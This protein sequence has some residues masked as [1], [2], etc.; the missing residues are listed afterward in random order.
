MKAK[1]PISLVMAIP[2]HPW[3]KAT[4]ESAAVRIAMTVAESG[5]QPGSL[6]TVMRESGLDTDDPHLVLSEAR[7]TINSNLSEGADVTS[8]KSLVANSGISCNGM[9]LAGRGFVLTES[10]ASHLIAT[11]GEGARSIIK[12]F[13]NGGELV[14]RWSRRY[15]IDAYGKTADDIRKFAP[16][17]F[18]HLLQAVKPE[19]DLNRRPSFVRRWWIF[20][21]PRSTFRPALDNLNR[22]IGT[23]ETAK[24]RLFQFLDTEVLPDNMVIAIAS[25]DAFHLGVL[26]SKVHSEIWMPANAASLGVFIGNVRYS[27]SRCF[28]PFPFPV[29]DE[30]TRVF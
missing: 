28:D 10:Q 3:T 21:E 8:A 26:S 2:D 12:P 24:H 17:T 30:F 18:Q 15:A 23:T 27:K 5:T 1:Q 25:D 11:D 20:G 29:T 13:I 19:R 14:R 6:L 22:Y 16:N 7:G 9:M 4:A